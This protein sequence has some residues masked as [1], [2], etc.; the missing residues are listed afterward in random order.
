MGWSG[1]GC[2]AVGALWVDIGAISVDARGGRDERVLVSSA[3]SAG[4]AKSEIPHST[5]DVGP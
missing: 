5:Y 1:G 3:V 4:G 2:V